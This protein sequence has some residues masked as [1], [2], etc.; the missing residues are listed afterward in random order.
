MAKA[1]QRDI[2]KALLKFINDDSL[3]SK[4]AIYDI[5]GPN[6][7]LKVFHYQPEIPKSSKSIVGLDG[8][9]LSQKLG[10]VTLPLGKIV[11]MSDFAGGSTMLNYSVG[12]IVTLPEDIV[13]SIINPAW[14]HYQEMM[15]ERPAPTSEP[16]PM[17]VSKLEGW[18]RYIFTASK[19]KLD[20]L[21]EKDFTFLVPITFVKSKM[22]KEELAKILYDE[23]K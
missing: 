1:S 7:I 13:T 11:R 22:N 15:K 8:Q 12:D 2:S 5:E 10:A 9:N 3:E 6:I 4:Y 18:S 17:Y 19:W 14:E 16:P 21:K 20:S 23:I